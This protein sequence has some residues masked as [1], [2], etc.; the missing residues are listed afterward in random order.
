MSKSE[1]A[2]SGSPVVRNAPRTRRAAGKP[3]CRCNSLAPLL[4]AKPTNESK[5]IVQLIL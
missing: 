1:A 2:G 5:S 3:G 4:C